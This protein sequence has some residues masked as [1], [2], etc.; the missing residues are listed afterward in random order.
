MLFFFWFLFGV[1]TRFYDCE[2]NRQ[3]RRPATT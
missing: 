3:M 1:S 2:V